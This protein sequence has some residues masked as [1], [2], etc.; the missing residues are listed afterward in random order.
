MVKKNEHSQSQDYAERAGFKII[1]SHFENKIFKIHNK[2]PRRIKQHTP[3]QRSHL[4]SSGS[5]VG[6]KKNWSGMF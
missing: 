4:L 2:L 1:P 5:T 6:E 3:I